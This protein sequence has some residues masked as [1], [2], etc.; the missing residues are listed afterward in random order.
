M[1]R[2][3]DAILTA[4]SDSKGGRHIDYKSLK[5]RLEI[6]AHRSPIADDVSTNLTDVAFR[7]YAGVV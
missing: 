1:D 2:V 4:E 6:G 3:D 5:L 7:L